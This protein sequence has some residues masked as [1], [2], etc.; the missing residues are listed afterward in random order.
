MSDATANSLNKI[1]KYLHSY[2]WIKPTKPITTPRKR[3]RMPNSVNKHPIERLRQRIES[4]VVQHVQ[5]Q[6]PQ[7]LTRPIKPPCSP[8]AYRRRTMRQQHLLAS[9]E[10][11][12]DGKRRQ[13]LRHKPRESCERSLAVAPSMLSCQRWG[14]I[15][16]SH[17]SSSRIAHS[18]SKS[19]ALR[20]LSRVSLH[21]LVRRGHMYGNQLR[22]HDKEKKV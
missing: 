4:N 12:P 8:P 3:H 14:R 13:D 11:E 22:Y 15:R 18:P 19:L 1:T 21:S 9:V 17:R 2:T 20:P 5:A 16:N 10:L 6:E 7:E